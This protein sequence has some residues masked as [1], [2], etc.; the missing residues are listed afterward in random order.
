MEKSKLPAVKVYHFV[1]INGGGLYMHEVFYILPKVGFL[2]IEA[3]QLTRRHRRF[4]IM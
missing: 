2:S 1:Y 4:L 3:W